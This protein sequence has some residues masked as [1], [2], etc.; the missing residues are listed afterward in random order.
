MFQRTKGSQG[1]DGLHHF[2]EPIGFVNSV[3]MEKQVLW[4]LLLLRWSKSVVKRSYLNLHHETAGT[5]MRPVSF[6][7]KFQ[8]LRANDLLKLTV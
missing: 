5:L 7:C 2:V 4:I 3:V 8:I 1:K 6:H